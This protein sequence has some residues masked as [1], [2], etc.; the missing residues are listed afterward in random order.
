[1]VTAITVMNVE[2]DKIN[3]VAEKLVELDGVSEVYSVGGRYDL[4]AIIRVK[5]NE[6]L[7]DI[8]TEHIRKL[9]GIQKTETM[10]AF[11]A[12][13]RHDLEGMFSIG[14]EV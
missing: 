1:M 9:E 11:R 6:D 14:M 4:I 8:V 3:F 13:S 12:Y 5:R 10:L 7:A 2:R